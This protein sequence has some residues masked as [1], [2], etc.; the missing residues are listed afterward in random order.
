MRINIINECTGLE[1]P[2]IELWRP[3]LDKLAVVFGDRGY[4]S[5]IPVKVMEDAYATL[6][7]VGADEIRETNNEQRGIDKTTDVLSFP[8]LDMHNG[9]LIDKSLGIDFELDEDGNQV[10]NLGDIL[11]NPDEAYNN[12]DKYGHSIEREIAFLTAHSLLHLVGYDHNE[13]SYEQGSEGTHGR[14][15]SCHR[16]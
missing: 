12:A 10:L 13:K 1:D 9:K 6:T 3:Y 8:I 2:K 7:F 15:R 11:I 4:A 5:D 14:N 16:R